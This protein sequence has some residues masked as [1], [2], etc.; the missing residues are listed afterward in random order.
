M[1][2]VLIGALSA[3]LLASVVALLAGSRYPRRVG[4]VGVAAAGVGFAAA[5]ATTVHVLLNGPIRATLQT[6]QGALVAEIGADRLSALLLVL[7]YGVSTVV[8]LFALRYLAG[9]RRSG[10]FTAATGLLT[11]AS[12]GLMTAGTLIGL[13]VC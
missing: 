9:D 11:S 7:V 8:Q 12:A 4:R 13:A 5:C 2:A 1:S 3:P 10:W 6:G